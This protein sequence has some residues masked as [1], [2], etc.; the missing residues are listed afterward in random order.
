[1]TVERRLVISLDEIKSIVLE[2]TSDGCRSRTTFSPDKV[3]NTPQTC[4]QGHRW[5]WEVQGEQRNPTTS[6]IWAWLILLKRLRDPIGNNRGFRLLLE[7][8]EPMQS[9]AQTSTGQQ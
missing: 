3:D 8:D 1:M 4:P 9:S 5:T 6:P 2:C 7:L